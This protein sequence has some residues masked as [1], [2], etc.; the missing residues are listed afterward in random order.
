MQDFV[1]DDTPL[2]ELA[3]LINEDVNF[4]KTISD[5]EI[6]LSYFRENLF[7]DGAYL[8]VIKRAIDLF[9]QFDIM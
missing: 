6:I 9:S 3:K 8:G 2:G 4:P 5:P 1:G 7:L